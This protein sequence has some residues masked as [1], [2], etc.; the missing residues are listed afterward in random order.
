MVARALVAWAQLCGMVGFELAGN[1]DGAVE[2]ADAF[3]ACAVEQLAG[4]L[5]LPEA[6]P[7]ERG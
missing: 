7:A 5:G 1:L 2:S 3:F 4:L 6:P